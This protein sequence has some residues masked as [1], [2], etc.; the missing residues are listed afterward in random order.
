MTKTE[1]RGSPAWGVHAPLSDLVSLAKELLTPTIAPALQAEARVVQFPG[2][3]GVLP[4]FGR[5]EP[6]DW[7]LGFEIRDGKK[8]HWTGRR[9]SPETFGHFGQSG[10]FLWVDPVA[11]IGCVSLSDTAFGT[12]AQTYWPRL[13]DRVLVAFSHA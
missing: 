10:S 12:W 9:N 1:L 4:G 7:G 3:T 8:P 11:R 5:Q 2:L 13:S 6:N